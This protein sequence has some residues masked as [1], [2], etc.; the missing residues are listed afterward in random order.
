MRDLEFLDEFILRQPSYAYDKYRLIPDS[1]E[2]INSFV[3][4]LSNDIFF[5]EALYLASPQLYE[6][7]QKNF[8]EGASNK[9]K[10][11]RINRS[12][13]KYFVRISTRCTPFG[14]FS[15]YSND[16]LN[17]NI[18]DFSP[19]NET[20]KR[21]MGIDLLFLY[22]VVNK[23]NLNHYLR[24]ILYYSPN[25]SLY[26]IGNDYRYI[27]VTYKNKSRFHQI[28]S[29]EGDEVIELIFSICTNKPI[30]IEQLS[31]IL[32][33][34]IEGVDAYEIETYI[35]SL[36]DSQVIVSD[37]EVCLNERSPI[38]QII[39]IL[40]QRGIQQLK[41]DEYLITAYN[42]LKELR[43]ICKKASSNNNF[44]LISL[45]RKTIA[46]ADSFD[47]E[48]EKQYLIYINSKRH[49]NR[50]SNIIDK[51]DIKKVKKAIFVLSLFQDFVAKENSRLQKFKKEFY[52]RYE[53]REIPLMI[54]LDN[55]L[56]IDYK[57]TN[58]HVKAISPLI[59][60]YTWTFAEPIA[61]E[62][63]FNSSLHEFWNKLLYKCI[64]N[65][66]NE[67]DL[68]SIDLSSFESSIEKLPTTFSVMLSK[69]HNKI[70]I[71][72]V[73]GNALN[74][75][76]RFTN[77]DS[78]LDPLINKITKIEEASFKNCIATEIIHL[79]ND[80]TANIILRNV[81]R[82]G[83]IPFLS[84]KSSKG[85]SIP[86]DDLL[87]SVKRNQFVLKSKRYNQEIK[88]F[89]SN[90][91]NFRND[92]L[93]VYEFLCDLRYDTMHVGLNI[94]IG[95]LNRQTF[96]F[97][98]RI[99]YKKEI[100]LS[101][102]TWKVNIE[103]LTNDKDIKNLDLIEPLIK[104]KN[105][106]NL[107]RFIYL[108]R[109]DNQLLIDTTNEYLLGYITEE[110]AKDK[111]VYLIE[112]LDEIT[113]DCNHFANE[114]IFSCINKNL[115]KHDRNADITNKVGIKRSFIPGDEW[116]Y[117]KVYLGVKSA[118]II[119]ENVVLPLIN[120]FHTN[121]L[122]E[123]W[124]FI[125]YSDPDFH[126]RIRFKYNNDI[127]NVKDR[128]M[129]EFTFHLKY[130]IEHHYIKKIELSTYNR[131]LERYGWDLIE[132]AE[133]IFN[134]DSEMTIELISQIR[135]QKTEVERWLLCIK[136]IDGYFDV[137]NISVQK[138]YKL[139]KSL[140]ES[141]KVEFN[142]SNA[143]K[144]E[145]NIKYREYRDR[146]SEILSKEDD[147]CAC[148][149]RDRNKKIQDSLNKLKDISNE[150]ALRL[151]RS[152]IHMT[153]NRLIISSPRMHELILYALLEKQYRSEVYLAEKSINNS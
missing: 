121:N 142:A 97:F 103:D 30:T 125:R 50:S 134:Y 118:D 10:V 81:K 8:E 3:K 49:A 11:N 52:E 126:L 107:P 35:H 91:H 34:S 13:V 86:V 57:Q 16:R 96:N 95:Q 46:V 104:F 117:Y 110:L 147:V 37:L 45:Y 28:T 108:S 4:S 42:G 131:E 59:D 5:K 93:P 18:Q 87:L 24:S 153:V 75:I 92:S 21:L 32:L 12:I 105:N 65:R 132:E 129:D 82:E 56:G 139:V 63:K 100:I 109:G 151:L 15:C 26:K 128:I 77:L 88:V 84:K 102:A 39:N 120:K 143:M 61:K 94:D 14:L 145:I 73:G 115:V 7:W 38:D 70:L 98:P 111:T 2:G 68:S 43:N 66:E 31:K 64:V 19:Q 146:I 17:T 106:N 148:I 99:T 40:E 27:E 78:D 58:E 72:S 122:I 9:D 130:Y 135:K 119:L 71:K 44:N 20:F 47:V 127:K 1:A 83:E 124:F 114:F 133:M 101:P 140:Y 55:E 6:S 53:E 33:E 149:I 138:K 41:K 89:N 136:A 54:A 74:L 69:T 80:R 144:K 141:F 51:Q 137:F 62:V 29:I 116:L 113:K 152:Y 25:T 123:K 76:G 23:L 90:A 112:C 150:K 85:K 22:K 36:I 60:N 79:P 67:I 48:Y